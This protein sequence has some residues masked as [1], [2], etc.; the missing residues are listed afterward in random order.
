MPDR[1]E[2]RTFAFQPLKGSV[3]CKCERGRNPPQH[4]GETHGTLAFYRGHPHAQ[5]FRVWLSEVSLAGAEFVHVAALPP[6]CGLHYFVQL[7][8]RQN[9]GN[10]Q[11]TPDGRVGA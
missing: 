7:R 1:L 4:I 5:V 11:T 6:H 9:R 8:Q 3:P 2:E 10:Q